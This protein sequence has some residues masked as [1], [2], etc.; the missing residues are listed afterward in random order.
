MYKK[1]ISSI[2]LVSLLN[3][4][5]CS[6]FEQVTAQNYNRVVE[7]KGKPDRIYVKTKDA[8]KYQ[9]YKLTFLVDND[10]LVGIKKIYLDEGEVIIDRK[11][12]FS[13]IDYIEFE[14]FDLGGTIGAIAIP[15]VLIALFLAQLE[16]FPK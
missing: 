2:L 13:D 1:I 12:A 10:S 4:V 3:L 16:L 11:I 8:K 14:Y 7:E 6:Y 15:V 5:G 9:F